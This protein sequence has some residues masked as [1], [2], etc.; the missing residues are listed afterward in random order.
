[1]KYK[2]IQYPMTNSH[3]LY[4]KKLQPPGM[5][6]CSRTRG[7]ILIS[8]ERPIQLGHWKDYYFH[9]KET[10]WKVKNI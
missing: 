2:L 1:M 9:E 6:P 4:Q 5:Y 3:S 7:A 10:T 8:S